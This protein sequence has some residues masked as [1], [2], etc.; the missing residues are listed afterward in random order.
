[1]GSIK[2]GP[3]GV[4]LESQ[5]S[6][7]TDRLF[8]GQRLDSTGLYYYGA[9]YYDPAI[10]RFISP[11]SIVQDFANP[12]T[13]NRYSYVLNNPLKYVDPTGNVVEI[14]SLTLDEDADADDLYAMIEMGLLP[15]DVSISLLELYLA[16]RAGD[17]FGMV[18]ELETREQVTHFG[19]G[20]EKSMS[21]RN[22]FGETF[23]PDYPGGPMTIMINPAVTKSGSFSVAAGD[24]VGHELQH[25]SDGVNSADTGAFHEMYAHWTG[26]R[27]RSSID[28]KGTNTPPVG[29]PLRGVWNQGNTIA[30]IGISVGQDPTSRTLDVAATHAATKE[31]QS[32]FDKQLTDSPYAG[33]GLYQKKT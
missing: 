19:W 20:N 15:P 8:T 33:R 13:L 4:C 6:I 30:G 17:T 11:D 25:A 32:Y 9:R 23:G 12:Q 1:M 18:R 26:F 22:V 7:G 29:D 24:V 14:G 2:Y 28:P 21:G 5:G 31:T 10:G 27:V 3:L 16:A